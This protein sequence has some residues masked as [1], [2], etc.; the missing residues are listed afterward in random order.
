V[1]Y[2]TP[3]AEQVDDIDYTPPEL[4]LYLQEHY[5]YVGTVEYA[6]LYERID[7]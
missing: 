7:P 5:R 6:D 3:E 4:K 2:L 1:I